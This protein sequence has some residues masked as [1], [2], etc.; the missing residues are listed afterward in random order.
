[1]K[2]RMTLYPTAVNFL[3][4]LRDGNGSFFVTHDPWTLHNFILRITH[5]TRRGRGMVVLL[6]DNYHLGLESQKPQIK[7]GRGYGYA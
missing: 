2:F 4:V 6:L 7:I 3:T 5:G 1:M